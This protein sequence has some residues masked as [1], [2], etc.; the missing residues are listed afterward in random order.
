MYVLYSIYSYGTW[1]WLW[2][3]VGMLRHA[4]EGW[5]VTIT[6]LPLVLVASN[7][8]IIVVFCYNLDIRAPWRKHQ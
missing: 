1:T 3:H 4:L 2:A 7:T 6:K 8:S 5:V